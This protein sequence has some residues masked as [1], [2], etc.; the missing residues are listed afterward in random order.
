MRQETGNGLAELRRQPKSKAKSS[1][2]ERKTKNGCAST[3]GLR[4]KKTMDGGQRTE[5]GEKEK[6]KQRGRRE[7][8]GG[9]EYRV[10][11]IGY[12][13]PDGNVGSVC[14]PFV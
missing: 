3:I 11:W 12:F 10:N 14:S 6:K 13:S 4:G 5:Q 9:G 8:E 7:E 2:K 1:E